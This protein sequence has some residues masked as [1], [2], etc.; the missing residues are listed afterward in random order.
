MIK[1]ETDAV[2][3][4]LKFEQADA[5]QAAALKT[6]VQFLG[7]QREL[8]LELAVKAEDG[9]DAFDAALSADDQS[10]RLAALEDTMRT[11]T[12]CAA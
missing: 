8:L 5:V 1:G 11:F 4:E 6:L 3:A 12:T 7:E 10:D 2:L 9:A